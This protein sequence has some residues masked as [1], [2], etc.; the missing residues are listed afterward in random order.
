[1]VSAY[2][3]RGKT[4][5]KPEELE[6]RR[7]EYYADKSR[8]AERDKG[9]SKRQRRER[10]ATEE[11]A[12]VDKA[13][14]K[15][16]TQG[17]PI[18]ILQEPE[19]KSFLDPKNSFYKQENE[20]PEEFSMR[21]FQEGG[22][23]ANVIAGGVGLV[24]GAAGRGAG[25]KAAPVVTET[26][27]K[28]F[29]SRIGLTKL[30]GKAGSLQ[31]GKFVSIPGRITEATGRNAA[32]NT[33]FK[34]NS[35]TSSLTKLLMIGAGFS[36]AGA[37]LA[38]D[39]FG[40]YP[41]AS[42]GKEETLQSVSFVMNKALDAGLYE[43]AQEILN[44]SNEIVDSAPTLSD[45]IPYLNVQKEFQRYIE[46]QQKNNEV[47]QK[48]IDKKVSEVGQESEFSESRRMADEASTQRKL[49]EQELDSQYFALIREKKYEEAE[50]LL[51][52]RIKGE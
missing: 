5:L 15:K 41:F 1:M 32:I 51:Q 37:S 24:S 16:T 39:I 43:E 7:Q 18:Q 40:T 49:E 17:A 52:L 34:A 44:A 9:T 11:K 33:A 12:R 31:R 2:K 22:E 3:K 26:A 4:K 38:K 42:F 27:L 19:K 45:K 20:T 23:T 21:K 13:E 25:I 50:E 46:K 30:A 6:K 48:I 47:W 8:A 14:D 10:S 35:K 36:L 28:L 29:R